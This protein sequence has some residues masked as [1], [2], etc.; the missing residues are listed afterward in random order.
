MIVDLEGEQ[1]GIGAVKVF[2]SIVT[3]LSA[4][5]KEVAD[6]QN[7][8]I[9]GYQNKNKIKLALDGAQLMHFCMPPAHMPGEGRN[10]SHPRPSGQSALILIPN[11]PVLLPYLIL[12]LLLV[13]KNLRRGMPEAEQYRRDM[14]NRVLRMHNAV[15]ARRSILTSS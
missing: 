13:I 7:G 14:R 2:A 9:L 4:G 11:R 6:R 5:G 10:A 15:V 8:T 3:K 12:R 1:E